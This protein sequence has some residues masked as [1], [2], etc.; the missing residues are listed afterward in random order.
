MTDE[1]SQRATPCVLIPV[2]N[3]WDAVGLLLAALDTVFTSRRLP[4]HVLLVDDASTIPCPAQLGGGPFSFLRK[5]TVLRVRRNLGHQRA[6]AI[7]LTFVYART[8]EGPVIIMDGDGEDDPAD[9]PRLLDRYFAEGESR[10]VF[11]ERLKRSESLVFRLGYVAYRWLH[12]ILTGQSVRVGNF[13]VV[14][15]SLLSALVVVSELW[16]HY[17]AAVFRARL[18][19]S[20]VLT[21]RAKRL[22]GKSTMNIPALVVHGISAMS[23]YSE[24]IGVRLLA[25]AL[26]LG[27]LAACALAVIVSLRVFTDAA[28]SY[29]PTAVG[30]LIVALFNAVMLALVFTFTALLG[31][32]TLS[33]IPERDYEWFIANTVDIYKGAD[34]TAQT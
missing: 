19:Y 8:Q 25:G 31:R 16:N 7:G 32:Q 26:A 10:V 13:S 4:V 18:P 2:F 5:I 29:W 33:F 14:P 17:A 9:V 3:D 15:R 1:T 6:I 20:T 23:V 22:V 28:L 12:R 24:T 21:T 27:V 30:V 11:A 34:E